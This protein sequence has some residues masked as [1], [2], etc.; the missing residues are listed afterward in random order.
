MRTGLV[1]VLLML[2]GCTPA[3]PFRSV[4]EE[5]LDCTPDHNGLLVP[6]APPAC[7]KSFSEVASLSDGPGPYRY[8]LLFAE[9]DDQGWADNTSQFEAVLNKVRDRL[10]SVGRP[11]HDCVDSKHNNVNLLVFVHG[12]KHNA[13]FND[14]NVASFRKVL[15]EVAAAECRGAG[16]KRDVIGIYVGWRGAALDLGEPFDSLSFWD[17]KSAAT[18]VAQGSVRELFARLDAMLDEANKD[19][20]GGVKTA[21]LGV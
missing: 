2:I 10:K 4:V 20:R 17:R 3:T 14:V 15:R 19:W 13:A 7:R 1:L 9:F 5:S 6:D 16:S 12:W 18:D 11:A 21:R 8:N